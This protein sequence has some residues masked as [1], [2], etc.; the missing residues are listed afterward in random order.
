VCPCGGDD[1]APSPGLVSLRLR[2][3]ARLS[4]GS[5]PYASN[6]V[7]AGHGRCQPCGICELAISAAEIEYEIVANGR[8]FAVH[9]AC[10]CIWREESSRALDDGQVSPN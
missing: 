4:D 9:L 5:L 1:P 7:W 6:C 10:Y 8:Q 3:R 2:V